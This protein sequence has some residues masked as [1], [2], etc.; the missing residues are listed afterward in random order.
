MKDYN[1]LASPLTFL[2]ILDVQMEEKIG[3][4]GRLIIEGY[5]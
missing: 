2:S 4:H 3:E 1:I 5:I